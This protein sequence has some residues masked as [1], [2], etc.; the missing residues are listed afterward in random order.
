MT[1]INYVVSI[2]EWESICGLQSQLFS[3]NERLFK[4]RPPT[5]SHVDRKSGSVKEMV[6]DRETRCYHTP[7]IDSC[8]F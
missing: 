5:G 4:V 1:R 2:H 3:E 7:L 6:Q 8:H